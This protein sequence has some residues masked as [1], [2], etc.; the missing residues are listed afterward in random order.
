VLPENHPWD[1]HEQ[2]KVCGDV[3]VDHVTIMGGS[4]IPE[5]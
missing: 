4:Q 3:I 1:Q 2:V 5:R